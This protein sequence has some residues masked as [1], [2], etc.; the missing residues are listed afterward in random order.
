LW[1]GTTDEKEIWGELIYMEREE[2]DFVV[3]RNAVTELLK[4][5]KDVN[6]IL[7]AKGTHGSIEKIIGLAKEKKV[8]V[9]IVDK[10]KLDA[11]SENQNHQ[12]IIAYVAAY[13]YFEVDDLLKEAEEKGE[14]PFLLILDEIEDPHNLG[15]II[16]TANCCG[17]HG[18]I[19]PKRRSVQLT[20][21]VAKT[22]AGAI[23]YTKVSR[24]TNIVKTLEYLKE[25]GIW[26]AGADM[27]GQNYHYNSD[28][29]GSL[30][31]VVGS[32]GKGIS[33]LVKE[34]CDF[35]V[36]IPMKGEITSLNASVAAAILMY[37][38]MRQRTS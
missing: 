32:E 20:S 37:E 13:K 15:A 26:V 19:I 23:E 33:R 29:K 38:A 21:V 6:K 17:V 9:Q 10:N 3:G 31:L 7:V 4:S 35:L 5:N 30:A 11:I 16:R 34:N 2:K 12:G 22:S 27:C 24:V 14:S 1:N 36:K 18:V 8:V 28:L 25:K